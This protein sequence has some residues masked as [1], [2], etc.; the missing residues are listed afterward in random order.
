MVKEII[1]IGV[2]C[3]GINIVDTIYSQL[4]LEHN[5]KYDGTLDSEKAAKNSGD[6]NKCVFS[7]TKEGKH[8]P[9]CLFLDPDCT[10]ND[11]VKTG[12]KKNL[13]NPN[14]FVNGN[15]SSASV[16]TKSYWII[17]RNMED[18]VLDRIRLEVEKCD[19]LDAFNIHGSLCGGSSGILTRLSNQLNCDFGKK[20]QIHFTEWPS[21]NQS[22]IIVEPYNFILSHEILAESTDYNIFWHNEKL[23]D[24]FYKK[25]GVYSSNYD[26]I[27]YLLALAYSDLTSPMR[28]EGKG[29]S[30]FTD[31]LTGLVTYPQLKH[32]S[33]QM[34]PMCE[35][36][37][38]ILEDPDVDD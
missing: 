38:A 6:I 3:P 14:N 11:I 23:H 34:A 21:P 26:H 33:Y 29:L 31:T 27:N 19:S 2:G 1:N 17:S 24:I 22:N 32:S 35:P 9:R 28:F 20:N 10:P 30:N 25:Y 36:E 5:I 37:D 8:V 12:N 15:E 13:Y 7:E 18:K 16:Y 4:A